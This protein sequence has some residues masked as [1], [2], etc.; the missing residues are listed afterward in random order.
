MVFSCALRKIPYFRIFF[1]AVHTKYTLTYYSFFNEGSFETNRKDT[2][3]PS[4]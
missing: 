1:S 4:N 2:V 3:K